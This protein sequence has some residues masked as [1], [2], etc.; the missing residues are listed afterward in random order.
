M[1]L[2]SLIF[3]QKTRDQLQALV[4]HMTH[5]ILLVGANGMGKRTVALTL[6]QATASTENITI[7]EP[8]EKG[9]ISIETTR[10]L[11]QRTRS[12]QN[13]RQIVVIDHAEA[14]GVE[15]QNAFLK[16]LEEPHSGVS[17]ILTAPTDDALLATITSRTQ[18][19]QLPQLSQ[20]LLQT[21]VANAKHTPQEIAQLLFIADGRPGICVRLR[22]EPETFAHY[23]HLMSQAKTLLAAPQFE[24]LTTLN[25]L[26]KN[27]ED[28][29][30]LLEAMARMLHVQLMRA[31]ANSLL[32]FADAIQLALTRL[33]QNGNP[34]AQLTALFAGN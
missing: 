20:A 14:M 8:D 31:P 28:A 10:Q 17:F 16:L 18:M 15:A 2:D 25:E 7:I 4:A 12:R 34:R 22:D 1:T 26:A 9:T 29:I 13:G 24:R 5:A 23:T 21:L 27:R 19:V 30:A 6:A 32:D 3:A 11:Y 33:A